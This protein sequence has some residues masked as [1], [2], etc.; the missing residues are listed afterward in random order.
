MISALEASILRDILERKR[1]R[2]GDTREH[3]LAL[4]GLVQRGL[5]RYVP[6]RQRQK[7]SLTHA[8]RQQLDKAE[9]VANG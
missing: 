9:R 6:E 1:E 5:V 8:G 3:H 2:T 4:V 7:F